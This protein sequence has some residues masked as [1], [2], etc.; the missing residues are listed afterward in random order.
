MF[1]GNRISS[2]CQ[3][4]TSDGVITW[5]GFGEIDIQ[6]S[7]KIARYE[8][9][10]NATV[11]LTIDG[12]EVTNAIKAEA[13]NPPQTVFTGSGKLTK[14][15]V[16]GGGSYGGSMSAVYVDD[17]ILIDQNLWSAYLS[18][19]NGSAVT[20]P[21]NGFNNN[22]TTGNAAQGASNV[23]MVWEPA[24]SIAYTSEV[25]LWANTSSEV[26]VDGVR[27]WTDAGTN[28]G[29]QLLT[30]SGSFSRI[31]LIPTAGTPWWNA[32]SVDG[33]IYVDGV[34]PSYGPNGFHLTFQDPDNLGLDTS[35][36]GNNFTATGFDT[37]LPGIFSAGL[38]ARVAS[39]LRDATNAFNN[40]TNNYAYDRATDGTSQLTWA[41]QDVVVSSS[42]RIYGQENSNTV[43]INGVTTSMPQNVWTDIPFTGTIN[44]STPLVVDAGSGSS[45]G[46]SAI[47]VDGVVLVDNKNA[48]YDLMQDGPSQNWALPNSIATED[49]AFSNANLQYSTV[50]GTNSDIFVGSQAESTG[51]WYFEFNHSIQNS[52]YTVCGIQLSPGP[53]TSSTGLGSDANGYAFR[54]DAQKLHNNTLAAYG[55]NWNNKTDTIGVALNLDDGELSFYVNGVSQGVAFSGLS[56]SFAFA[57]SSGNTGSVSQGTVN[58]GQQPFLYTP[59]E[60]FEALQTQNLPAAPI[61]NGRDNFGAVTWTGNSGT[62]SITGLEFQ[63]DF[64]WIKART[65]TFSH[66]LFDVVRGTTNRLFSNLTDD[67]DSNN[68]TLTS[69]DANGFSLGNNGG[70]NGSET[71]VAWCW[72]APDTFTPTVQSGTGITNLQGRRN[73]DAGFS[74]ITFDG[75]GAA[76]AATITHGL[77]ADPGLVL[78]KS[79]QNTGDWYSYHVAT[80]TSIALKLNSTTVDAPLANYWAVDTVNRAFGTGVNGAGPVANDHVWYCWAPVPGYSAFG[81]YTA[82]GNANGPFVYTGFRPAFIMLKCSTN[83]FDWQIYDSTRS[84][85]NPATLTLRPNQTAAEVTSGND[86]DILSNG[87]KPRDNGSINNNSGSTYVYAC[88][89]E[90]PFGGENVSPANAR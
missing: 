2:I 78:T 27:I 33:Q 81:S 14:M 15:T 43:T 10:G 8:S 13:G 5:T 20:T 71:Y 89:A 85:N 54:A 19:A 67:E 41:P 72:N 49:V 66:Q 80:G 58:F 40:N 23:T 12:V 60:G 84:P 51:K 73:V 42:L 90:N 29:A 3:T 32:I 83:A 17:V 59:P 63:P 24:T 52:L 55:T 82:N 62:Q 70:V 86:L 18:N 44:A 88:F 69:F 68:S 57:Y 4:S 46:I 39:D 37:Q 53:T 21:S 25:R 22:L 1:D 75:S 79:T 7:L 30:G 64:V 65:G 35:G 77:D 34:N 47:E 74:I 38:S 26:W 6:S 28:F 36:N 9:Y 48:D 31:E 87:F 76:P 56:G 50:T 11:T 61:A 45:A 16:G